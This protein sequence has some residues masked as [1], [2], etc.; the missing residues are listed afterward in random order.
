MPGKRTGPSPASS[1]RSLAIRVLLINPPDELEA[2][3]GSGTHFVQKYEPL[4][5]LYIAAVLRDLGHE[6]LVIDAHAED[7]DLAALK[8]RIT[9]LKPEAV[10]ITTLTCSGAEVYDLGR[11]LG[12]ELPGVL[13]VLGNIH[14][15]VFAR[16]YLEHDCCD[17]VVHGDGED[18]MPMLLDRA[19]RRS[20][21]G[22]IPALSYLD[23]RGRY[24]RTGPDA[25][26]DDIDRLPP[27]ARELV[28]QD[29]YRLSPISNQNYVP[30]NSVAKTVATSRGCRYRCTFCV[31]HGRARPRFHSTRRVLDELEQLETVQHVAYVYIVDPLFLGDRERTIEICRGIRDRGLKIRWGCDAHVHQI[32]PELV[33]ELARANCYE[34]SLGIE[35]GAQRLLNRVRKGIKVEHARK[36]VQCIRDNS[37]ISVEGLFILGLPGETPEE[38][39]QT[40]RLA[41]SL[42]LHMAQFSIMTPYPGSDLFEE[43]TLRGELDSGIRPDGG[44]DP[45]VWKGYSSYICFTDNDP[46]WVTPSQTAEQLRRAQKRA[47][48]EFYLR[49]GPILR[50]LKR[51]RPSTVLAMARIAWDGMF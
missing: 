39:R 30:V 6:V 48:R 33:R 26:I 40:I 36:A 22:K 29:R 45:S 37:R 3:L 41:K 18:V 12:R 21:W 24:R 50:Q 17:A 8:Q 38:S 9:A 5:L 34:L 42:P 10:G 49:P 2:M 28:D 14:A 32:T 4:G 19:G 11:W 25:H 35:S 13:R 27:P 31:V 47:F 15:S 16:Q 46:V 1:P 7:L 43:L 44:L 51:V 23:G 20:A